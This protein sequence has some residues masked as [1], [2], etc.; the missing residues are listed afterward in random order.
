MTGTSYRVRLGTIVRTGAAEPSFCS[1]DMSEN[2]EVQISDLLLDEDNARLGQQQQSQQDVYTELAK[3]QGRRILALG[4]DIVKNGLDPTTWVAIVPTGDRRIRY[5]VVE[6]NRR[7]LALK[8]LETPS[9]LSHALSSS[10]QQRLAKL[11]QKYLESPLDSIQCVLFE[12]EAESR[13]WV[14]LRHTG[15]NEGAGLVEWDANEK[16]RFK[17]RHSGSRKPAGQILDFVEKAGNLSDTAKNAKTRVLTNIERLLV[18]RVAKDALGIDVINGEVVSF[19]PVDQVAKGL[20]RVVEDFKSGTANVHDVYL[21]PDREKYIQ[22]IPAKCLP[23]GKRLPAAVSLGNLVAGKNTP[24]QAKTRRRRPRPSPERTTVIPASCSLNIVQ[25]RINNIYNE[26]N[27]LSAETYP[28]ACAVL[29]RVFME[30]STDHG[31]EANKAMTEAQRRNKPLAARLKALADHYFKSG[32]I[33][34]QLR[35]AVVAIADRN[36]G[37]IDA[38]TTTMNQYVHNANVHPTPTE[39]RAGW[40]QLQPFME[41]IWP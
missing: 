9:I 12:S 19:Y 4:D 6:G 31:L 5:R 35:K 37:P 28:N 24:V 15:F 14:E 21:S 1:S 32:K 22:G 38:S 29:L 25:P 40:D 30:L 34:D 17:T 26:L 41:T 23:K 27:T 33:T 20:S 16:D 11:S 7:V 2:V 13:H 10:D 3:Q 36:H 18:S 8:A 39:L